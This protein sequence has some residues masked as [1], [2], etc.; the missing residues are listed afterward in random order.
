MHL[1]DVLV[2]LISALVILLIPALFVMRAAV[3][4]ARRIRIRMP[5]TA[6]ALDTLSV[7][8]EA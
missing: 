5:S 1:T 4:V 7:A 2:N 6:N 3:Q 8:P